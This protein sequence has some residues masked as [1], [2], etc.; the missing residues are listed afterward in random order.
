MNIMAVVCQC[1]GYHFYPKRPKKC[2]EKACKCKKPK[3]VEFKTGKL[4]NE[5]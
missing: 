5:V 2:K 1:G 3:A 4:N